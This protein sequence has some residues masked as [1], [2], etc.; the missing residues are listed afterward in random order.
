MVKKIMSMIMAMLLLTLLPA[1]AFAVEN[2]ADEFVIY[3]N[4]IVNADIQIEAD[5]LITLTT[6]T[7]VESLNNA[8]RS[9]NDTG[10]VK[11]ATITTVALVVNDPNDTEDIY[12]ALLSVPNDNSS[13]KSNSDVAA[14]LRIYTTVYYTTQTV[15]GYEWYRLIRVTGGNNKSNPNSHVIGSGFVIKNQHVQYGVWGRNLEGLPPVTNSWFSYQEPSNIASSFDINVAS[16]HP[17]WPTVVEVQSI[18]GATYTVT[19]HSVRDGTDRI[20][21]IVNNP[22]NSVDI[23]FN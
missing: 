13:Y 10:D 9:A 12:N 8:Q 7:P 17:N 14:G 6:V 20:L 2:T 3:G 22:L 16:L 4:E 18:L 5:D 19:I 23:S 15:D 11:A 1:N 21:E